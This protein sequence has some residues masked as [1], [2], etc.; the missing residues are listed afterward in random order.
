DRSGSA[1]SDLSPGDVA[2]K[3]AL[4]G[5]RWLH[6]SGITAAL[7]DSAAAALAEALRAARTANVLISYDVNYREKLW[8]PAQAREVQEPLLRY[9]DVLITG[10]ESARTVFNISGDTAEDV[11]RELQVRHG[12]PA[13]ALTMR[14][15]AATRQTKWRALVLAGGRVHRSPT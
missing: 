11:A 4:Q 2:W 13:I 15:A 6:V 8:T 1:M 5:A 12:V 7:G 9:A 10:E 3:D 14:A